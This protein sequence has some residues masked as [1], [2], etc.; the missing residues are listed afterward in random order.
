MRPQLRAAGLLAL[1]VLLAAAGTGAAGEPARLAGTITDAS[2]AALPGV[3]ITLRSPLAPG[4]LEAVTDATG[5]YDLAL[6]TA[7]TYDV[8]FT[9]A[10]FEPATEHVVLLPGGRV[11]LHPRLAVAALEE[12]VTVLGRLPV[13]PLPAP[14]RERPTIAAIPLHDSA[15][16]C[17][18]GLPDPEAVPLA[19][20]AGH[21][22][23]GRR[24]LYGPDDLLSLELA[25]EHGLAAGQNLVVRRR[26]RAADADPFDRLALSGEHTAGLVQVV[27]ADGDSARV[28]VI[29]ACS[30]LL[31]G[32]YLHRFEPVEDWVAP[33]GRPDFDRPARVL[34]PDEG[35][36]FGAPR[37]LMVIDRGR[38]DGARPGQ[39]VT[40]FRR[41]AF[42]RHRVAA[43]GEGVI[44]AVGPD[45]ARIRVERANDVVYVGDHVAPHR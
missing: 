33:A 1:G 22:H 30:E 8:T 35:H 40:L 14:P 9:L 20:I 39:R 27:E 6:P 15:S 45:W 12:T 32:D 3:T 13:P 25:L 17:G 41:P 23:D 43:I 19:R 34:L 4:P 36:M 29:Y 21:A 38:H 31:A 28:V 42:E 24:I 5:A 7:G 2:G 16:V 37:R 44:V 10:G 11:A 26:F 18:P